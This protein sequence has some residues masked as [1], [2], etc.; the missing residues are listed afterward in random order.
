M[1]LSLSVEKGTSEDFGKPSTEGAIPVLTGKQKAAVKGQQCISNLVTNSAAGQTA[2]DAV[3][4]VV[5][6]NVLGVHDFGGKVQYHISHSP[7]V[8]IPRYSFFTQQF[9]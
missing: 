2:M 6:S 3:T 8:S 4:D 1:A 9:L 7:Y 5:N